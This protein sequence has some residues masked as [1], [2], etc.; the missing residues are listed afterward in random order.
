MAPNLKPGDMV[1]IF[2]P[3]YPPVIAEQARIGMIIDVRV[4]KEFEFVFPEYK[5][6]IEDRICWVIEESLSPIK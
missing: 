1:Y 3:C 4:H 2:N 6:L 5:V